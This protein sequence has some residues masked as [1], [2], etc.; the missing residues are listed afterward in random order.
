ML[1]ILTVDLRVNLPGRRFQ[2]FHPPAQTFGVVPYL[3]PLVSVC[4]QQA[5]QEDDGVA[6][7]APHRRALL[8]GVGRQVVGGDEREA[9]GGQVDVTVGHD[10]GATDGDDVQHGQQ[11]DNEERGAPGHDTVAEAAPQGAEGHSQYQG[12]GQQPGGQRLAGR[13]GE[14]IQV[15]QVAR[16]APFGEVFHQGIAAEH[17]AL[18]P[19]VFPHRHFRGAACFGRQ[20]RRPVEALRGRD[21]EDEHQA[22]QESDEIERQQR[23]DGESRPEPVAVEPAQDG[24][25]HGE[26]QGL[27]LASVG[28]HEK[29]QRAA[30]GPPLSVVE[31]TDKPAGGQQ[32]EKGAEQDF[33]SADPGHG[34]HLQRMHGKQQRGEKRRLRF[35]ARRQPEG[36]GCEPAQ[37]LIHQAAVGDVHQQAGRMEHGGVVA[38]DLI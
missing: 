14:R 37:R 8:A 20:P 28:T 15:E 30:V 29:Q 36:V 6:E 13:Y 1:N 18:H 34:L 5:E 2:L 25:P 16:D 17:Y 9:C 38:V 27:L 11:V 26:D 12:I 32:V 22:E 10:G 19:R 21:V 3:R 31:K 35:G 33:G 24:G 4:G 7:V 23:A